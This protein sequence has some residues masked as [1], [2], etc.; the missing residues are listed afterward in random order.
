MIEKTNR[1]AD[2]TRFAAICFARTVA[3]RQTEAYRTCSEKGHV[4]GKA[5]SKSQPVGVVPVRGTCIRV[6]AANVN[7]VSADVV[8][9]GVKGDGI[10]VGKG[11]RRPKMEG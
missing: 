1:D 9:P 6:C 2:G 10:T 7:G 11:V 3:V 4:I 8:K 5:G